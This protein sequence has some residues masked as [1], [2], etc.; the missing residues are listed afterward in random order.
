MYLAA[1]RRRGVLRVGLQHHSLPWAYRNNSGELV[2]FDVDLIKLL[3]R[4]L[5]LQRIEVVE[6]PLPELERLL[7]SG[8]LDLAAGGILNTPQR[9]ASRAMSRG[10]QQVHLALVVRDEQLHQLQNLAT[11]QLRRPLRL[12]VVDPSLIGSNL[13]D[14]IALHLGSSERPQPLALTRIGNPEDFFSPSGRRF[15]ALLT[16]AEEG[17]AWAVLH[18]RTTM[19]TSFGPRLP[20][21]MVLLI[22]GSDDS[23]QSFIDT[24]LKRKQEQGTLEWLYR[25]WVLVL[26]VPPQ[27]DGLDSVAPPRS[28]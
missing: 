8:R 26:P 6:A 17:S 28:S 4:S 20:E 27:P 9:A 1:I 11:T 12:A 19:L 10:Y 14:Q 25:H 13:Q 2:G 23:L 3:A 21:Q 7:Q 5:D 24:W 16:S 18:P 15:D 22:G